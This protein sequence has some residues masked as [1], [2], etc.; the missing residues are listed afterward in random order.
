M[1]KKKAPSHPGYKKMK[2][3]PWITQG[4]EIA[5]AGGEGILDNYG[6]VNV[7]GRDTLDSLNARNNAIYQR[8]FSDMNQKYNDTMNAYNA[9]N[10]GR[11]G[12]LQS[13]PASYTTDE[14]QKDF[15]RQMN[16]LSYNKAMNYENLINNELNR[17]YN[18]LNMYQN[19]Y[20]YGQIP[21]SQDVNNWNI[22]NTNRNIDYQNKLVSYRN[23][24]QALGNTVG[25]ALTG[26]IQ[27]FSNTAN[28][29]GALAG[30]IAGGLGGYFGNNNSNTA[31][32][33]II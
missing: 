15:Q 23:N 20:N 24:N 16:D 32:G 9:R 29:W 33:G 18:T 27:G 19:M 6:K 5:S 30:G 22:E 12:T 11:F 1:G 28:P 10:F 8:A 13:T 17:R 25:G 4:R 26:A 31:I 14:Y 3:T 7:F 2:D 21:Y